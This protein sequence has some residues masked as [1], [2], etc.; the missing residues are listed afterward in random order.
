MVCYYSLFFTF[1]WVVN[2]IKFI[3][4]EYSCNYTKECAYLMEHGFRYTFVKVDENKMTVWKFKKSRELFLALADFY[5]SQKN[6]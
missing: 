4:K 3:D 6:K 5:D 2:I 1:C